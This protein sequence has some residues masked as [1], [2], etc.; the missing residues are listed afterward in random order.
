MIPSHQI[1]NTSGTRA[2]NGA[3]PSAR[4]RM[5]QLLYRNDGAFFYSSR[6]GVKQILDS[7]ANPPAQRSSA[8]PCSGLCSK[9]C[10]PAHGLRDTPLSR[11]AVG[12][13]GSPAPGDSLRAL[14]SPFKLPAIR[15]F[16][17][18]HGT[19]ILEREASMRKRVLARSV[20]DPPGGCCRRLSGPSQG[21]GAASALSA[22]KSRA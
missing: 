4:S 7:S 6:C 3:S 12:T 20:R 22:P 9:Y 13:V 1:R 5:Q 17:L 16:C 19:P 18:C 14:P 11:P 21:R 8:R 10:P 15:E 2:A